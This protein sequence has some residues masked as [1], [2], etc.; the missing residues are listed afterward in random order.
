MPRNC[1]CPQEKYIQKVL[2]RFNM[3]KAKVVSTPLAMH[4]KLSTRHCPSSDGE[5]EDMK[6][7]PYASAVGSL[8]YAMVC[9][10]PDIAHVVGKPILCGYTDSDMADDVDTQAELIAAVEAC[11]ELIW[12]KR[13]LGELGCAQE[14]YVLYCDN[15]SAIHLGK[16]STFHGRSKHIDVRYNWI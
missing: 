16:N 12:M 6:K 8:M 10:R 15:Q 9:T 14:R 1:G 11:K 5:K 4:F 13:F 2:R 7:V 3:D